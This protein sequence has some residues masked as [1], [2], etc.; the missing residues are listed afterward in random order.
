MRYVDGNTGT[1]SPYNSETAG[2]L[3]KA[4][5]GWN[6][7]EGVSGNGLDSYG[8]NALPGGSS[9]YEEPTFDDLGQ[10]N[11]WQ[12]SSEIDGENAYCRAMSYRNDHAY[13][14][15]FP[16]DRLFS[17]RCVK[18]GSSNPPSSGNSSSSSRSGI[19]SSSVGISS[20][21]NGNTQGGA[22]SCIDASY[23]A[24]G[25]NISQAQCSAEGGTFSNSACDASYAYCLSSENNLITCNLIGSAGM[26]SKASCLADEDGVKT[27]T[28]EALCG[29]SKGSC[30]FQLFEDDPSYKLCVDVNRGICEQVYGNAFY[31]A[32]FQT[33]ECSTAQYPCC[34]TEDYDVIYFSSSFTKNSC[35]SSGGMLANA[36]MC[37]LLDY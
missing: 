26:P 1:E 19:S 15:D 3:L 7:Y 17:V 25:E 4:T 14:Y 2:K 29:G 10:R 32:A 9:R 30:N 21:S 31:G 34:V 12:T 27:F 20:S 23:P 24:C 13:S 18:D 22:G 33:G 8:F 11:Y 5:S 37:E 6:D 28:T 16:K 35:Y 36:S